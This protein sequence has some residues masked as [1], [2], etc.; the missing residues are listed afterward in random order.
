MSLMDTILGRQNVQQLPADQQQQ[1][2]SEAMRRFVLGSLLGGRGLAS[3]YSEAQQVIP[4]MQAAQQQRRIGQAVEQSMVPQSIGITN[5]A[6]GSQGAMLLDE[7]QGFENDPGA[8]Q[9]VNQA[10]MRNPN[11]P[12]QFNPSAF[13]QNIAPVLAGSSPKTALE[14][15]QMGAPVSAEGGLQTNRF[16]GEI[17]GA[18]PTVKDNIQTQFNAATGRF[19]ARPVFGGR[20]AAEAV[21]P[22]AVETGQQINDGVVQ[23]APGYVPSLTE[24]TGAKTTAE[25]AAKAQFDLVEVVGPDGTKYRVPRASLLGQGGQGGQAVSALSPAMQARAEEYKPI[26][27]GARTGFETARRRSGTIQQLRNALNNPDFATGAFTQQKAALTNALSSLGV[28]GDRANSF[29]TSAASFRQGVNDL[30]MGSLAELVGAISN[31]EID[32][33]Q[34]RFGTITD[35][36][37]SNQYALDLLEAAD[38]R[39]VDYYN[40]IRDNPT[41]EAPT[42]WSQS[43]EG[44]RSLFE[45]PK[46]RKWLPQAPINTGPDKG[47]KAYQL[48]NGEWVVFD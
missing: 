35:P 13:V 48:P 25:E 4:G 39:R 10:A 20:A 18:L 21:R 47:K 46:L 36:V 3:G 37:Q 43:P 33:S 38:K 5:F 31:F 7:L 6:P 28:T 32:F 1:A 17:T 40:F 23:T 11:I 24:I 34:K 8:A 14:I 22:T 26:L 30:T 2:R 12:R 44:Q 19:E 15:A 45:D 16:T 27:E 9:A 42:L 41:P 29:L